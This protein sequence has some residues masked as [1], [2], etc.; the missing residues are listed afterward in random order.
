MHWNQKTA[1]MYAVESCHLEA[2]RLLIERGH[3][4]VNKTDYQG[5][6]VLEEAVSQGPLPMLML[7]F[8]QDSLEVGRVDAFGRTAIF[9][10]VLSYNEEAVQFMLGDSRVDIN[11]V[12]RAGDSVLL[13]AAEAGNRPMVDLLLAT[14]R[15]D[16]TQVAVGDGRT[17]FMYA[18][19]HG[20]TDIVERLSASTD[21]DISHVDRLGWTAH[22][23]AEE[24]DHTAICDLLTA[25]QYRHEVAAQGRH[26]LF[27]SV[28][29]AA[30]GA[31]AQ[32]RDDKKSRCV[33]S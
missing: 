23:L 14:G 22:R 25:A 21:I 5:V 15:A 20:W 7:L 8:A 10:A 9:R 26:R 16:T 4:N 31:G 27:G 33:I 13:Y 32:V 30:V 2:A 6:S 3:A 1:L 24:N 19:M 29:R 17:L 12:D 18:A 28:R 11:Q